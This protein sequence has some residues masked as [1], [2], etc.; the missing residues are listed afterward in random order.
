M[1]ALAVP[2][3]PY[4]FCQIGMHWNRFVKEKAIAHAT[5]MA[6]IVFATAVKGWPP[7]ILTF[8]ISVHKTEDYD[9][10]PDIEEKCRYLGKAKGHGLTQLGSERDLMSFFELASGAYTT[11]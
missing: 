11:I 7:N 8:L 4:Q 6:I 3:K 10:P 5:T 9:G 2:P 1:H